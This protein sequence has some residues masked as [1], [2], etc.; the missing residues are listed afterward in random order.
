VL[1]PSSAGVAPKGLK[2]T[3]SPEFCTIWTY[4]GLP[5]ISLP[6]LVGENNLQLGVQLIGDKLDDLRLLGVANWL[7]KN[8]KKYAK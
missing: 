1:T 8:S 7:E 3:G 4:M 6:L 5:S 2:S